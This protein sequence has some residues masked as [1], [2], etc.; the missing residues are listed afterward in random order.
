GSGRHKGV[1]GAADPV[2][3]YGYALEPD[4]GTTL[5][6]GGGLA[7][8]VTKTLGKGRVVFIPDPLVF[9]NER[10]GR[11][12]NAVFL[13]EI[14]SRLE[15]TSVVIDE[16]HHG[17]SSQKMFV[18]LIA[19]FITGSPWGWTMLQLVFGGLLYLLVT[20][21]RFERVR[22][23]RVVE[24][25]SPLEMVNAY[26]GIFKTAEARELS[27]ELIGS[28]LRIQKERFGRVL[29]RQ[30]S[31]GVQPGKSTEEYEA[32]AARAGE[33]EHDFLD[34]ARQSGEL[35][36]KIGGGKINGKQ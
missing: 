36:Q 30:R 23:E 24:R 5:V 12:D 13:F 8:V 17:F 32:L 33:G 25:R 6:G 34:F 21:R 20:R 4:G 26:S 9:S 15:V 2:V 35:N 16:Y 3:V 28:W 22:P 10:L 27:V 1:L 11:S 7:L 19:G 31:V 18:Q 14:L 29:D